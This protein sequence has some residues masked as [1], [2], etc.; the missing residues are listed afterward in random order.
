MQWHSGSVFSLQ[1]ISTERNR[2]F[3][4]VIQKS[5]ADKLENFYFDPQNENNFKCIF[6][7][8]SWFSRKMIVSVEFIFIRCVPWTISV[9]MKCFICIIRSTNLS[10]LTIVGFCFHC[11]YFFSLFFLEEV[12]ISFILK[13]LRREVIN[14]IK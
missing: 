7:Q 2:N 6:I 1:K 13:K 8:F 9:F 12:I 10:T 4:I 11:N 14:I 5:K 3:S